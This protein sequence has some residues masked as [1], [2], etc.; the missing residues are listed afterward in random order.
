MIKNTNTTKAAVTTEYRTVSEWIKAGCDQDVIERYMYLFGRKQKTRETMDYMAYSG[1]GKFTKKQDWNDYTQEITAALLERADKR[2]EDGTP[3]S[4]KAAIFA[5]VKEGILR[6]YNA[7]HN[8]H[9]W[10]DNDGQRHYTNVTT[11]PNERQTA[12]GEE[13]Y[14]LSDVHAVDRSDITDT[15]A[16]EAITSIRIKAILAGVDTEVK[17]L[18]ID[19]MSGYTF[20]ETAARH[21]KSPD[22]IRMGFKRYGKILTDRGGL[23]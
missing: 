5:A 14:F 3:E 15:T 2:T 22:Q 17:K 9:A 7:T 1:N 20:E 19:Y 16:A 12:D 18:M 23:I 4:F 11:T 21:Q 6:Q 13:M 10:K 8:R